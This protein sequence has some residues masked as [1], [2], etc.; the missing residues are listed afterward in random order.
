MSELWTTAELKHYHRTGEEPGGQP[1][2]AV[3]RK[4]AKPTAVGAPTG[5]APLS[6]VGALMLY[7]IKQG[8]ARAAMRE[9]DMAWAVYQALLEEEKG[10]A[11]EEG[12]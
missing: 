3:K 5:Q 11:C 8:L 12:G 6:V 10:R 2:K 9:A 7:Q 4:A 1:A